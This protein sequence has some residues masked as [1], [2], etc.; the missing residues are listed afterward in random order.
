MTEMITAVIPEKQ[1]R[2]ISDPSLARKLIRNGFALIDIKPKRKYPRESVF[3]FDN[4]DDFNEMLEVFIKER[5]EE[6]AEKKAAEK[7][8]ETEE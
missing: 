1:G 3:V 6:R 5:E 4:T 8:E 2:I 7:A